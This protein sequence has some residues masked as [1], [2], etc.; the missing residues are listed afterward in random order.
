MKTIT[1][2]AKITGIIPQR[3]NDY[4][5]AGLL[6]KPKVRNKYNYRLYDDKDIRRLWQIRF[7]KE[8]G[9]TIPQMQQIF[10]S[11]DYRPEIG[12]AD[13]IKAL[14]EKKKQLESL[15]IQ[16][17]ALQETGLDMTLAYELL[18]A[19][20]NFT[21]DEAT[22]A[23]FLPGSKAILAKIEETRAETAS[24]DFTE[25]QTD[26]LGEGLY[27]VLDLIDDGLLPSDEKV[28]NRIF[29]LK[30]QCRL[31]ITSL[32]LMLLTQDFKTILIEDF[33]EEVYQSLIEAVTIA[34]QS[35]INESTKAG[36]DCIARLFKLDHADPGSPEVQSIIE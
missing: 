9:Y 32:R 2:V 10:L 31:P 14:E 16:A 1:E 13:Q 26:A 3:I 18:P 22:E 15:L 34:S 36:A 12:L 24:D 20:R 29:L 19:M 8:L 6:E 11:P 27:D 7:Y 33:G 35:E 21:Y 28:Q 4:E 23:A 30:N 17:R 5:K 25:E